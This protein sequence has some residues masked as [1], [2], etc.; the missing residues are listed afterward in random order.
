[1][2]GPPRAGDVSVGAPYVVIVT[3]LSEAGSNGGAFLL[4][5]SSLV[6]DGLGRTNVADE[7]LYC[8]RSSKGQHR[9]PQRR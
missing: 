1:M 3:L 4:N 7:L 8:T 9:G 5:D 6:G 2:D